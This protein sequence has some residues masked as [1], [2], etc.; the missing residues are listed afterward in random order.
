MKK[1]SINLRIVFLV[2]VAGF[3]IASCNKDET[4]TTA[5]IIGTW[6][7][8]TA[9]VTAMDGTQLLISYM[10]EYYMG[11]G[12]REDSA[13]IS[14]GNFEKGII[15]DFKGTLKINPDFTCTADMGELSL[16][17]G[18]T[19]SL[20]PNHTLL[21][22]QAAPSPYDPSRVFYITCDIL[23]LTSSKL[24]LQIHRTIWLSNDQSALNDVIPIEAVVNFTKQ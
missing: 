23:E 18:S 24:L 10:A 8:E 9:S 14:A 2:L 17:G 22:I 19:W 3:F 15:G 13:L 5:S 7:A 6:T 16:L 4:N 11:K 1:T 12:L 20:N 21:T